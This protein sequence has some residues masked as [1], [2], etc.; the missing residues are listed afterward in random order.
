MLSSSLTIHLSTAAEH[1]LH[2][3]SADND[4]VVGT[5]YSA[6]WQL[7]QDICK[8]DFFDGHDSNNAISSDEVAI[9]AA[10]NELSKESRTNHEA[11][12][13]VLDGDNCHV[14]NGAVIQEKTVIAEQTVSGKRL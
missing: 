10:N 6:I 4:K 7:V 13:G 14:L 1:I 12:D 11:A 2:Y 9:P 3:L 8:G 5:T